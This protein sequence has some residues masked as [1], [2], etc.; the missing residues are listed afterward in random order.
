MT[1]QF[2]RRDALKL[3][4]QTSAIVAISQFSRTSPAYA[5]SGSSG[6][7]PSVS[8]QSFVPYSIARRGGKQTLYAYEGTRFTIDI[9]ERS[10]E[11]D[12]VQFINNETQVVRNIALHTLYDRNSKIGLEI[13]EELDSRVDFLLESSRDRCKSI[14]E[15]LEDGQPVTDLEALGLLDYIVSTSKLSEHIQQQYKIASENSKVLRIL[16]TI[17]VALDASSLSPAEK[18]GIL[19][20]FAQI[21]AG[22]SISNLSVLPSLDAIVAGSA[23][24]IELKERYGFASTASLA[25]TADLAILNLLD[26]LP[27]SNELIAVYSQVRDGQELI[28]DDR[29]VAK[30]IDHRIAHSTLPP[31]FIN[32]YAV[33]RA[34][35]FQEANQK[36]AIKL[37]Q[38]LNEASKDA[39]EDARKARNIAAGIIPNTTKVLTSVGVEASTGAAI[40]SLSGG[41]AM[42]ATLAFLGGGSVAAGGLGMLG[43]LAV[44]TGGAALIGAAGVL[45]YAFVSELDRQDYVNLGISVGSGAVV[46]TAA[47]VAAWTFAG[48][49]GSLTGAAALSSTIAALGGVSILTGGTALVASGTAF[50]VWSLLKRSKKRDGTELQAIEVRLH[51]LTEPPRPGS[52]AQV[53]IDSLPDRYESNIVYKGENLDL[54]QAKNSIKTWLKLEEDE[55]ILAEIDTT[56]WNDLKGGICFTDRRI[57]WK[58]ILQDAGNISYSE[59][60]QVFSNRVSSILSSGQDGYDSLQKVVDL[61]E[62]LLNEDSQREFAAFLNNLVQ[63]PE[64]GSLVLT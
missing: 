21:T 25:F 50:V 47:T 61:A 1:R 24:P 42:N 15:S 2:S 5:E 44:A 59:L 64:F 3:A 17:Q 33:A 19:G 11:G 27:N 60:K 39:R 8:Y 43:G 53:L 13:F 4:L 46:G 38:E 63:T 28:E 29:W 34:G 31:T 51:A 58:K 40:S 23:L 56:F 55:K 54:Q 52:F 22:D 26:D 12:V 16:D 7:L 37:V 62:T 18:Q 49:G 36:G 45:S 30:E 35:E 20:T 14:Y 9:P 57:V 10:S 6:N 32:M 48:A 41:A